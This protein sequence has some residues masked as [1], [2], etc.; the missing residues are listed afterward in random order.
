MTL[1]IQILKVG[2]GY[3]IMVPLERI[4]PHLGLSPLC[5]M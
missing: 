5:F 2:T 1:V 3:E 4:S